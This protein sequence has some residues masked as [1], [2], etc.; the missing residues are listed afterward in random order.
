MLKSILKEYLQ[1]FSSQCEYSQ[2]NF[3]RWRFWSSSISKDMTRSDHDKT[4]TRIFFA[5]YRIVFS[6]I[7]NIQLG[8]CTIFNCH[9]FYFKQP[10]LGAHGKLSIICS[11][12]YFS[13]GVLCKRTFVKC[14]CPAQSLLEAPSRRHLL[15]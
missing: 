11:T 6:V 12:Q 2:H 15:G 8:S 1:V 5:N 9:I 7:G 14:L 10:C 4:N 13:M 3:F